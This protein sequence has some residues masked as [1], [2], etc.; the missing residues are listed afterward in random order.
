[1][2]QTVSAYRD[3]TVAAPML[4]VELRQV[5][6][7]FDGEPAVRT[8]D[9]GI[10]QGE[11][12]SILGPSG[13]G[14]TTTLRLI[15]GFEQPTSGAVLIQGRDV[16]RVPAYRRSVNTVFQSYAL[17]SHLTVWDNIAFGLRIKGAA[18]S[19]MQQ[20]VED[21]LRLVKME[22]FAKR[23][24]K[25][26]S[27]GQKQRVALARALVNRPAVMLLDEPLGA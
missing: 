10:Q 3:T 2:S 20:R 17:F 16:G 11:F 22:A 23:Y 15:A 24:P 27:G 12:F 25:Q 1:M 8:I 13:C 19:Q 21:A 7:V 6:K 4:D 9:L 18:R 26:L 14:K 5:S